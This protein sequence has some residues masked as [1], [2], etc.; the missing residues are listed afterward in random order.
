MVNSGKSEEKTN[1]EN[2]MF[3]RKRS[4]EKNKIHWDINKQ[5]VGEKG[6]KHSPRE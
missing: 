1:R 5:V 4:R 3:E 6:L 2:T